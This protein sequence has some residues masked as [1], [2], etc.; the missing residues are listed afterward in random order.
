MWV[1][2]QE[3]ALDLYN[4]FD[5]ANFDW[6]GLLALAFFIYLLWSSK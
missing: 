4:N 3:L 2:V 1:L 5:P 6:A